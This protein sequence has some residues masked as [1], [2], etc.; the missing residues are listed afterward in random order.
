M[1]ERTSRLRPAMV[2]AVVVAAVAAVALF[3]LFSPA[4]IGFPMPERL[5][6]AVPLGLA[7]AGV[8]WWRRCA[9]VTVFAVTLAV[10]VAAQ[11]FGD[12]NAASYAGP[13]VAAYTVGVTMKPVPLS[14]VVVFAVAVLADIVAVRQVA[15][16]YDPVLVGWTGALVVAAWGVGRYVAVRRAYLEAVLAHARQVEAQQEELA[17]R[18]VA[19]ER[20]RIARDLHDQVAHQLGVV[21]LQTAAAQRWLRRD[22]EK[23]EDALTAAERASRTALETMPSILQALRTGVGDQ[24]R[25][26]LPTLTDLENLVEEIT[27]AGVPVELTIT[28]HRRPLPARLELTA[29]RLVQEALTNVVKHAQATHVEVT[30][31]FHDDQLQVAVIDDGH[32]RHWRAPTTGGYGLAGMRERVDLL[33]GHLTVGQRPEGG[34][35]VEAHLPT[36]E[37][38][39]AW[40]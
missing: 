16:V 32:G 35:A 27:A 4:V 29:Y 9:P 31:D 2:D 1:N 26:P 19:E 22:L 37:P 23:A 36:N 30:L 21:S 18:A 6:L 17:Q 8:L 5:H 34:F 10:L 25:A 13:H 3:G 28:G 39:R 33:G 12:V 14:A 11:A 40:R 7:Q 15:G 20:R 38:D 24:D